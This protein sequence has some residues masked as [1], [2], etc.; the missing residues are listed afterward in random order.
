MVEK[1][2]WKRE[3]WGK[4]SNIDK[5]IKEIAFFWFLPFKW[6]KPFSRESFFPCGKI[7]FS[8]RK[9]GLSLEKA[10]FHVEKCQ[11]VFFP[12]DFQM[13]CSEIKS[14][15]C[16]EINHW[17]WEKAVKIKKTFIIC[18]GSLKMTYLRCILQLDLSV[19]A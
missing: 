7:P 13:N 9:K 18:E 16:K 8:T 11:K 10:F 4:N 15:S 2:D 6:K 19:K 3:N 14:S 1:Q 5:I 12:F 17:Y